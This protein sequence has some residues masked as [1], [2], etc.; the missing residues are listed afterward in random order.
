MKVGI[1]SPYFKDITGGG[2]KHLLEMALVLAQKHQVTIAITRPRDILPDKHPQLLKEYRL[3]YEKFL[4]KSLANLDF[5][6]C[7]LMTMAPW[8]RKLWWTGQFDYLLAATDGSFFFS[9]AKT[10]NL[11][12]QVPFIHKKFNIFERLKLANWSVRNANSN[13]TKLAIERSWRT[14]VQH[15]VYPLIESDSFSS[16]VAKEKIILGVGRFYRHLH[17]KRQD[18]LIQAFKVMIKQNPQVFRG[19]QLVL[20]GAPEDEAY[21]RELKQMSRGLPI[22]IKTIVSKYE[23]VSQMNKAS[24]F[25]HAAGYGVNEKTHP[26]QVEHF[27]IV[28][29]EAMAAGAVPLT[30]YA[31]GQK[32]VLGQKMKHL[33][34]LT[35][36]ELINK[37]TDLIEDNHSYVKWQALGL[38]QVQKFAKKHFESA[39]WKMMN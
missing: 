26:E 34:W 19:W 15:V 2:E 27:G 8:W 13:F 22:C 17:A 16:L 18:I 10:S 3:V 24:V 5:C 12:L 1:F 33:G 20:I 32:E 21:V 23:V 4:G 11:H 31:G 30:Y 39:I 38:K 28:T 29:A 7:P 36:S 14:K 6:F 25:W 9:L 37:T 35:Q